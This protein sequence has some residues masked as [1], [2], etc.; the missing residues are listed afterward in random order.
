MLGKRKRIIGNDD[1]EPNRPDL[2]EV[3]HPMFV[4]VPRRYVS[5]ES[6]SESVYDMA[7]HISRF[8]GEILRRVVRS[9]RV[10]GFRRRRLR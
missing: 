2:V 3:I 9:F 6:D 10:L 8:V 4:R 1:S 5:D 7:G